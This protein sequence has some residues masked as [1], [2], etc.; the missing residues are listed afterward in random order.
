MRVEPKQRTGQIVRSMEG[1]VG[2]DLNSCG[3]FGPQCA[4][5]NAAAEFNYFCFILLATK[6]RA[7]VRTIP[8]P[9]IAAVEANGVEAN[10]N[11]NAKKITA[12]N[13]TD[14]SLRLG[15]PCETLTP[16]TL[17]NPKNVNSDT[18]NAET[19]PIKIIKI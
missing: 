18:D 16:S 13:T 10:H 17:I 2:S 6:R 1:N 11:R 4:S 3:F 5:I 9:T 14:D 8:T 7:V 19:N 15:R 12:S